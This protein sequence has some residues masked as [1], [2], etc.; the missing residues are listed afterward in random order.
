MSS[1][2]LSS[3]EQTENVPIRER[4]TQIFHARQEGCTLFLENI[5]HSIDPIVLKDTFSR[6]GKILLSEVARVSS[7]SS[8]F[9]FAPFLEYIATQELRL[10]QVENDGNCVFRACAVVL[11][12]DEARHH[13]IRTAVANAMEK[14]HA[15]FQP[16]LEM[17]VHTYIAK[18]RNSGFWVSNTWI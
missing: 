2:S 11:F 17:N 1:S 18:V 3:I 15:D 14:E 16:F 10:I 8:L 5:H 6:F 12:G 13:E 4:W 9:G 7:S